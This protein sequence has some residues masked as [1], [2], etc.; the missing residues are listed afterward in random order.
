M[1]RNSFQLL[2][3]FVFIESEVVLVFKVIL[4]HECVYKTRRTF[5]RALRFGTQLH[6]PAALV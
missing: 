1:I 4:C 6:V 3:N 5:S 2:F